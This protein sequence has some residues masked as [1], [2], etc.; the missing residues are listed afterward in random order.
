M[1]ALAAGGLLCVPLAAS[2]LDPWGSS[3]RVAPTAA[4]PWRAT[5]PLPGV[6]TPPPAPV[7]ESRYTLAQLTQLALA[8]NPQTRAAWAAAQAAAAEL[9]IAHADYLPSLDINASR[10]RS[11]SATSAGV[12]LPTQTRRSASLSLSYLLL[13][14][15]ARRANRDA[16]RA[17]LIAANL[18]H[19]QAVQD[20]VLAVEQAYYQ[21]LGLEALVLAT[22]QSLSTAETNLEAVKRRVTA[23][24]ATVGDVY[25]VETTVAQARLNLQQAQG[26]AAAAGGTLATAAGLAVDTPLTLEPWPTAAPV[27]EVTA[28]V[29][30]LLQQAR[31]RRPELIAAQARVD[32]AHASRRAAAGDGRPTLSLTASDGR[33]RIN[34][35]DDFP[36]SSVGLTLRIPLF[37]GFRTTY[38]IRRAE[39][40][41][42]QAEANRDRLYYEVQR[43]VWESYYNQ[44]TAA[45]TIAN[46]QALRRSA[47]QAAE[48]ARARYRAGVGTV[49]EVVSTQ[50]AQAQADVQL[51]QAQLNWYVG[52]TQLA[53]ALGTLEASDGGAREVP[54]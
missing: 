11:R 25:Q 48:V 3:Q 15:G 18:E 45:A 30:D 38:E 49:L 35:L 39:A 37:N 10:T 4:S 36:Q 16:G 51:I 13:D 50:T 53:H 24:L 43:Q 34:A 29:D 20:V 6:P 33:T 54:P 2:A 26:Q 27:A 42:A 8:H 7:G 23:G 41:R 19:N 9:G 32:V 12:P 17:Q 31:A 40:N 28:T 21:L 47:R 1:A 46:A 44:R 14:F 5:E 52:L 22:Q